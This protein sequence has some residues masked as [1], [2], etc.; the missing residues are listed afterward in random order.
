MLSMFHTMGLIIF[1][2]AAVAMIVMMVL[3]RPGKSDVEKK[4]H[5]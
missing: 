4:L 3:F 2:L 5:F 1:A